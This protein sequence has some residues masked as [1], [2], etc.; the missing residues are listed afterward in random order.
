MKTRK[1]ITAFAAI[2]ALAIPA[3]AATTFEW[4]VMFEM[5]TLDKL[6]GHNG[7]EIYFFLIQ[8]SAYLDW[9][10]WDEIDP[11]TVGS[12]VDGPASEIFTGLPD[13]NGGRYFADVKLNLKPSFNGTEDGIVG[14]VKFFPYDVPTE[15]LTVTL[16]G[17]PPIEFILL[18]LYRAPTDEWYQSQYEYHWEA[19]PVVIS[20]G[21]S[22]VRVSLH[23]DV[24][25][26]GFANLSLVPEPATGLLALAGVAFLFRRKRK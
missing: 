3:K 4:G 10:N 22:T 12:V 18:V 7:P 20:S 26:G 9:D 17:D 21:G 1:L 2:V 16:P 11:S 8:G 14:T 25:W 23:H 6:T 13:E 5:E 15:T 24:Y 19:V